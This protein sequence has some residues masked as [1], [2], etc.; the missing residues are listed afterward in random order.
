MLTYKK[1]CEICGD[2]FEAK[3]S[4]ARCC[5]VCRKHPDQAR[6]RYAKA[7]RTLVKHA[8]LT[9]TPEERTCLTIGN[10]V[11]A[12]VFVEMPYN[13]IAKRVRK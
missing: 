11:G 5:P 7:E 12:I 1:A 8:G 6:R 2:E 3:K 10:T 13:A 9:R 4:S